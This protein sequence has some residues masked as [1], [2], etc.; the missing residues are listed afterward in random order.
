MK[1][2]VCGDEGVSVRVCEGLSANI[3]AGI[4]DSVSLLISVSVI[5]DSKGPSVNNH[6]AMCP[7]RMEGSVYHLFVVLAPEVTRG[8]P[9]KQ[10]SAALCAYLLSDARLRTSARALLG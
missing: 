2:C 6:D 8:A 1:R 3:I 9:A 10:P 5:S 4:T 7:V